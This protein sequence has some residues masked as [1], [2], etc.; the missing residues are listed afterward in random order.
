MDHSNSHCNYLRSFRINEM[1]TNLNEIASFLEAPMRGENRD[2]ELLLTDSRSLSDP[3]KSLF[4]PSVVRAMMVI[5]IYPI[6]IQGE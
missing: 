5:A 1:K 3:A 6:F 2:I 4:L